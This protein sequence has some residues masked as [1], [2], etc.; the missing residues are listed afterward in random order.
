MARFLSLVALVGL[1]AATPADPP[2]IVLWPDAP[3]AEHSS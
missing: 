3:R 1:A 2:E